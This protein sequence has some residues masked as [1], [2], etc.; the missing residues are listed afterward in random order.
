MVQETI[1]GS[2]KPSLKVLPPSYY[3]KFLSHEAK[4]RGFSPI[5]GLLPLES[6]PG[7]ISL[8]A[9]KPNPDT[10]PFT[11]FRIESRSAD[12]SKPSTLTLE[13]SELHEA[14]QYGA[15]A[16]L[17]PLVEWMTGLQEFSHGRDRTQGDWR[18]TM[19]SGSQ[20]VV[21]KGAMCILN[22]GDAVLV[23]SPVYAGVLP[24]FNDRQC[25]KIEVD[26]DEHGIRSSSLREILE[27]WPVEKPK[28][29]ALYTVPYGCNPTGMTATLER[30]LEVLELAK[31]HDFIILEDDPYFYLYYGQAPR[32]PSY[33]A[34]EAQTGEVGRVL[35]FDSFSKVLSA[36]MRIGCASG[37]KT[38]IDA[39][40]RHTETSNLQVATLT[41]MI[42]FKLLDQWGF[43]GFITHTQRVSAFY[44]ERRDMFE[45][46]M[47]QHLTGLV[48]W[49]TPEAGMF[50]WFKLIVDPSSPSGGD[51][52]EAIRNIAFKKGVLALPG[53]IF[54]PSGRKTAYVRA[55]FSMVSQEQMHLALSRLKEAIL[56]ARLAVTKQ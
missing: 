42:A 34:L 50:V 14:L 40:D 24:V 8:L 5:R 28:P 11:S 25:E 32:Y 12:A 6:T 44:R 43:E 49:T 47:R 3:D 51:S 9:G 15:T 29:K 17:K 4:L 36:G 19:G 41:Q 46:A 53:T 23:E 21:Y 55:S 16:G 33:F 10:F 2:S 52:E 35:R 7:L 38:L 18:V 56:E 39:I 1:N 22:P 13:G 54:L 45:D 26:T 31:E 48:E 27:A 37:P 20:D 30:R